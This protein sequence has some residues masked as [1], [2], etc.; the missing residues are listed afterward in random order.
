[1]QGETFCQPNNLK[2]LRKYHIQ[3]WN[4]F[5]VRYD[6]FQKT[7]LTVQIMSLSTIAII[8]VTTTTPSTM[9]SCSNDEIYANGSSLG[10]RVKYTFR[11]FYIEIYT[12]NDR[13]NKSKA[14]TRIE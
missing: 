13:K 14:R 9:N 11:N 12:P 10:K 5:P 6:T 8:G 1:M 3:K 7:I 2:W 4:S